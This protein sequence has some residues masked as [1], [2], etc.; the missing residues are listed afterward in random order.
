M[1]ET[2]WPDGRVT[3]SFEYKRRLRVG[4]AG[5]GG[6]SWRNVYPVFQPAA[7]VAVSGP[8]R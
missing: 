8:R 1:G 2:S 4:F 3:Y 6:H 5:C 7:T